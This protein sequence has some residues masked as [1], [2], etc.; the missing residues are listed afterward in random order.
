MAIGKAVRPGIKFMRLG[1]FEG[2]TFDQIVERLELCSDRYGGCDGCPDLK[3]CRRR[4]DS[5]CEPHNVK[6]DYEAYRFW[7][8]IILCLTQK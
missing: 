6:Q 2:L 8:A 7:R 1:L 3:E 4:Y 5:L